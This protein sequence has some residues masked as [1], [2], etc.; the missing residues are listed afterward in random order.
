MTSSLWTQSRTHYA[1]GW[2][3]SGVEA[4]PVLDANYRPAANGP[5]ASGAVDLSGK[6]WPDAG[7]ATHRGAV[8]P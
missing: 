7:S 6:S 4:N 2:E 8:T 3:A 5:A 1:P